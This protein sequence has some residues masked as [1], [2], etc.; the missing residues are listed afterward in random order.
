MYFV[1]TYLKSS[2]LLIF[3]KKL[4]VF[5]LVK[6][7]CNT[8]ENKKLTYESE[9]L[10]NELLIRAKILP[11]ENCD[12]SADFIIYNTQTVSLIKPTTLSK[13]IDP[14]NTFTHWHITSQ[15]NWEWP[16]FSGYER[17]LKLGLSH[18]ILGKGYM[19]RVLW[20]TGI[21]FSLM[22]SPMFVVILHTGTCSDCLVSANHSW[23][24]GRPPNH[25]ARNAGTTVL[26][27]HSTH[28]CAVLT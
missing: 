10:L 9:V 18:L 25:N 27:Y 12:E 22:L 17:S 21:K 13:Y 6:V 20:W 14:P 1:Y 23:K 15:V 4:W 28:F 11:N 24:I 19:M 2:P 8:S 7:L 3:N 26:L 5:F 16:K